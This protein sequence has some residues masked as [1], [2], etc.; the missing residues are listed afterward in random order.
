MRAVVQRVT[1]ASVTL[2]NRMVGEIG[3]GLVVLLG[4]ASEDTR[5]DA[6]YL[7]Q[8]IVTLRIFDDAEGRMNVS[9]KD[10]DGALLVVSQFTLF[11]DV[12]RGLRPSWSDAAPPQV[13]EPLYEYFVVKCREFIGRVETGSFQKMMQLE[14]VNDGPVTLMLDSRKLF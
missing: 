12:R 1:R 7:A 4:V 2:D 5:S 14:L 10:T 9:L 13:A 8:K 6:D 3:G 11:G